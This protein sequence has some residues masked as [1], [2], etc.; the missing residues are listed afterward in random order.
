[1]SRG[2]P[3]QRPC[4]KLARK[5]QPEKPMAAVDYEFEYNLRARVPEHAE[6]FAGWARDA[7]D[8][9]GETLKEGCAEL[10]LSYGDTPR[11]IID[12]FLP[13][14]GKNA[15]LALFIHGGYWRAFDPS[16]YSHMAR[17]LNGRDVAVAVVG[18]DLCPIVTI[19]D[20][21]EQIRRAC[22]FL[23]QRFGRRMLV[24]GHSAGGHL[25]AC[26]V[27]TD[28]PSLYPK[29]PADLVP[30]GYAISGVFDLTPLVGL[31]MNQ[32]LRLDAEAAR[33]L[34]P[35]CWPVPPGRT[36]DAVVGALET[37]E[38]KRQSQTMAETWRRAK[39]DTRY[40]EF[41]GNHFTVIGALADPK[42]AMV[43]RAAELAQRISR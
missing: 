40:Q 30:A 7:E 41:P 17:G 23:W 35:L 33:R 6:I 8:Y 10:G 2:L 42:S 20:I 34:S 24:S 4:R 16:S 13:K 1:M 12:L 32:D 27:A 26:M 25:A 22:I 15:P 39:A 43:A 3:M 37:S 11:Q 14:A 36:L 9:R 28:W 5:D 18:Y 31:A 38:F 29:A 21:V 19:G